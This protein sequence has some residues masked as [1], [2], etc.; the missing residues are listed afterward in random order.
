[1][2]VGGDLTVEARADHRSDI[3]S[4]SS[5]GGFV[6]LADAESRTTINYTTKA[7]VG[8]DV[9]ALVAGNIKVL[10]DTAGDID[11]RSSASG[12][13]FGGDAESFNDVTFVPTA[14]TQA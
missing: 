6:G 13:G 14:S 2:L 5:A 9:D 1:L 12:L 4:R 11:S 10:S 7:E 8:A 3:V